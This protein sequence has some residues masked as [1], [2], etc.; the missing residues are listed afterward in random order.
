MKGNK[1][2]DLGDGATR[3]SPPIMQQ[4]I[5]F[6]ELVSVLFFI[7]LYLFGILF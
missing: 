7:G 4:G 6:S 3:L 2:N 1:S 5:A